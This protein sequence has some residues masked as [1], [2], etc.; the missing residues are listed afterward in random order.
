M[1]KDSASRTLNNE[2]TEL[3]E[4]CLKIYH[5]SKILL[6]DV[7][8][9]KYIPVQK[10]YAIFKH[11]QLICAKLLKVFFQKYFPDIFQFRQQQNQNLSLNSQFSIPG[12]R[13][14]YSGTKSISFLG[15]HI[16]NLV[17]ASFKELTSLKSYIFVLNFLDVRAATAERHSRQM[18]LTLMIPSKQQFT[19]LACTTT[20][21]TWKLH[22]DTALCSKCVTKSEKILLKEFIRFVVMR[23]FM[24][25][26]LVL[27]KTKNL[28]I[29]DTI[30][31]DLN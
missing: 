11:L 28:S 25:Q 20:H 3:H 12:V 1:R 8:F 18:C 17:L 30:A 15:P 2:I 21:L 24:R 23:W 27:C 6:F 19:M 7:L 29:Y 31:L 5:N 4:R 9:I 26:L 14:V 22:K 10:L 16:R 13:P